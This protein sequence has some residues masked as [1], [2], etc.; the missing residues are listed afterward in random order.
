MIHP[1]A[2]ALALVFLGAPLAV[3]AQRDR[4]TE[5]DT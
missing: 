5:R 3:Q 1:A 2:F 4:S